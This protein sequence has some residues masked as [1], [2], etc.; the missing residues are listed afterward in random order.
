M[1]HEHCQHDQMF[2]VLSLVENFKFMT[3]FMISIIVIKD[4]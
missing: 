1:F 3:E 2:H 4:M